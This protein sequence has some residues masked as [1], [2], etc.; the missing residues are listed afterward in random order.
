M[1]FI[2]PKIL[3]QIIL[4]F[5]SDDLNINKLKLHRDMFHD[6]M[7]GQSLTVSLFANVL[8]IT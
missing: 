4:E 6:V 3:T 1:F 8:N 2:H 7:K 5:S